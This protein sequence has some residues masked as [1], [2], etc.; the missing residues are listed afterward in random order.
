MIKEIVLFHNACYAVPEEI[1]VSSLPSPRKINAQPQSA[2]AAG[3][4]MQPVN[5]TNPTNPTQNFFCRPGL[6]P[7]QTALAEALAG[8]ASLS[9]AVRIAGI[10]RSTWYEWTKSSPEFRQAL[11]DA[12]EHYRAQL[13]DS[14]HDLSA[15]ALATLESLLVSPATAPGIRLRAALAILE[16]PQFPAPGWKLPAPEY[17]DRQQDC[18]TEFAALKADYD[19]ARHTD[20]LN[21]HAPSEAAS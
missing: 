9:A 17:T 18:A 1:P 2:P 4:A 11:Q 10:H 15:Q 21:R 16:R 6:S 7:T 19:A 8:G 12:K 20:Y 13:R 3:P 14:L 5:P